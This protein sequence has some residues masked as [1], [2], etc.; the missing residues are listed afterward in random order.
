[1]FL[2]L[3]FSLKWIKWEFLESR[4]VVVLNLYIYLAMNFL[5]RGI[6][7]DQE[8]N[9][10]R[11]CKME[12]YSFIIYLQHEAKLIVENKLHIWTYPAVSGVFS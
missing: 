8:R 3:H 9:E 12:K 7:Y 11:C 10:S 1:M 5:Q 2:L 4:R 6:F